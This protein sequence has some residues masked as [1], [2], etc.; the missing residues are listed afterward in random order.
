MNDKG[1]SSIMGMVVCLILSLI[2][3]HLVVAGKLSL[4]KQK[5]ISTFYLCVRKH[6]YIQKNFIDK[7]NGSNFFIHNAHNAKIISLF[8]PQLYA[9]AASSEKIIKILTTYQFMQLV[10]FQKKM[11]KLNTN[12][13]FLANSCWNESPYHV[14]GFKFERNS[15]K[16]TKLRRNKWQCTY[17]KKLLKIVANFFLASN[18]SKNLIT[19]YLVE[20]ALLSKVASGL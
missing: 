10:S 2:I 11:M 3:S 12:E 16:T 9:V 8:F 20:E 13:C 18:T 19:D 5:E 6:K 4:L 1:N 15:N 14:L 7:I 17:K